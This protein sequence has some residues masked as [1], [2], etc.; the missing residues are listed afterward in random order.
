MQCYLMQIK[1]NNMTNSD[2]MHLTQT[3]VDSQVSKV[4]I[5]EVC[6]IFLKIYLVEWDSQ[7]EEQGKVQIVQ[8][9][10]VN[11]FGKKEKRT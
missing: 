7:L 4:S 5:L 6:Q 10:E 1:E 2:I 8:E 9:K 11:F 3:V